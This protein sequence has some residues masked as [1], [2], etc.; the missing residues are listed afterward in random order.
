MTIAVQALTS[1]PLVGILFMCAAHMLFPVM[2]GLVQVL[3][4]RYSSE[5]IVWARTASHLIFVLALFTPRHGLRIVVSNRP[6][7]QL[8]RSLLVLATTMLFF[9]GLVYVPLAKAASISFAGPFL[10]VLLAWPML[11]ERISG[12]RLAAVVAA[13]IG[14]LV[15]VRPGTEVFHWGSLLILASAVT[16]AFDQVFTR[17]V[18][19][20][21]RAETSAIYSVLIGTVVMS[22]ITAFAWTTPPT[23]TD[24]GLLAMLGVI[25]GLGH[26]CVAKSMTY[27]P[28]NLV[29]P[30]MYVQMIGAVIVGYLLS[31]TLPDL[32]TW[33]G[34]AIIIAAGLFIG[35]RE[36]RGAHLRSRAG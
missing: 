19:E 9:S 3:S 8:M 13:F 4:D 7:L 28:A 23:W 5:Q 11:G 25:G 34:S 29:A 16:Y 6:G 14:V 18:A 17:R 12:H 2:N 10:I 33:V 22:V 24:V 1:R 15:V 31:G 27:A 35:L 21:D 26:W 32:G 30:F 20:Y 36:A